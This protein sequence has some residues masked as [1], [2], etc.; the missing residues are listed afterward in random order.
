MEHIMSTP[1]TAAT[2]PEVGRKRGRLRRFFVGS[3]LVA[4]GVIIGVGTSALSQGYG[5]HRGWSDDGPGRHWGERFD[6]PRW[7]R[8]WDG[9][10]GWF[11]RDRDDDGPR[12]WH[13]GGRFGGTFLTPGR[14]ERMVDRLAWA[15]DASSEQKQK[16]RAIAQHTVDEL[17]PLR[18]RHLDGRRQMRDVLAAPTIDRGRLEALRVEQM[19][20]ADE[21]SRRIAAS[22]A[23]AADVLTPAQRAD[24]ARRLERFG[25]RRG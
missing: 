15:V 3:A 16:L 4:A 10:R 18:E 12:F 6:G 1:E 21:A 13:R 22:V 25:P 8:D 23:E 20:L 14:I 17:S 19:R 24:L 7:S 9:P 11:G 5:P 2:P